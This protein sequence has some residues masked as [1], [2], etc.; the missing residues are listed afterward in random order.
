MKKKKY[1]KTVGLL[2]CIPCFLAAFIL[3]FYCLS[4][5]TTG[6][7]NT[8]LHM[9]LTFCISFGLIVANNTDW[10]NKEKNQ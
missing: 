5:D 4:P 8:I 1:K 6:N 9:A 7:L 2:I 10:K 3:F